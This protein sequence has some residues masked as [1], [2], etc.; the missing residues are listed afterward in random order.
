MRAFYCL[1]LC[2]T[3]NAFCSANI[4]HGDYRSWSIYGAN[5]PPSKLPLH[6]LSHLSYGETQPGADGSLISLDMFADWQFIDQASPIPLAKAGNIYALSQLAKQSDTALL[7]QLGGYGSGEA[8]SQALTNHRTTLLSNIVDFLQNNQWQGVEIEWH[9]PESLADQQALAWLVEQLSQDN[10]QVI[11]S[12]PVHPITPDLWD[13]SALIDHVNYFTIN[14]YLVYGAWSERSFQQ[15]PIKST[16]AGQVSWQKTLSA[17]ALAGI[18]KEKMV[19]FVSTAGQGWQQSRGL[20]TAHNGMMKGPYDSQAPTGLIPR[21]LVKDW[22]HSGWTIEQDHPTAGAFA[23]YNGDLLTFES[24]RAIAA[25]VRFSLSEGLAGIGIAE[26]QHDLTEGDW[27][28]S[29][30]LFYQLASPLQRTMAWINSQRFILLITFAISLAVGILILTARYWQQRQ[31]RLATERVQ[32]RQLNDLAQQLARLQLASLLGL[33]F[34]Q[35]LKNS[36]CLADHSTPQTTTLKEAASLS[37]K[38]LRHSQPPQLRPLAQASDLIAFLKFWQPELLGQQIA[39][40]DQQAL[41]Q[42]IDLWW[43]HHEQPNISVQ[44]TQITMTGQSSMRLNQLGNYEQMRQIATVQQWQIKIESNQC[45]LWISPRQPTDWQPLHKTLQNQPPGKPW[46]DAIQAFLQQVSEP[47]EGTYIELEHKTFAGHAIKLVD[48]Q[49]PAQE[50]SAFDGL[51]AQLDM[52]GAQLARVTQ[53]PQL[54]EDLYLLSSTYPAIS[55]IQSDRGYCQIHFSDGRQPKITTL[56]L[57]A[58]K[59]WFAEELW[60]SIHRSYLVNP[61]HCLKLTSPSKNKHV[62]ILLDG[63]KLPVAR[64]QVV[65]VQHFLD[66]KPMHKSL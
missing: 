36:R 8:W 50:Q 3:A 12:L 45:C 41:A 26:V 31:V 7:L 39:T 21:S 63:Q 61:Q 30:Q 52:V 16:D 56:R 60:L 6:R 44:N 32:Q 11:I 15:W 62:L 38:L 17:Y 10:W 43:Q 18:P 57:N 64:N 48:Q 47:N 51:V 13:M 49:L 42:F 1:I 2:L 25:K 28:I 58:I 4:I 9:Y 27:S 59:Q 54:L 20:F 34:V 14:P 33:H 53:S 35:A 24:P 23:S 5:T 40:F 55:H 29:Q 37:S 46:S 65:T 19:P 22:L 66:H